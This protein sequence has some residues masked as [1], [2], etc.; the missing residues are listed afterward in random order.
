MM[1]ILY[2][3][4]FFFLDWTF[5]GKTEFWHKQSISVYSSEI[6]LALEPDLL[7]C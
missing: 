3:A 5:L 1:T 2:P 7:F 4:F 6:M